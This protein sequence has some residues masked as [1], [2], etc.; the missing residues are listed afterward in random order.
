MRSLLLQVAAV[1]DDQHQEH[2]AAVLAVAVDRG[3]DRAGGRGAARLPGDGERIPAHAVGH[4]LRG[5]RVVL[6]GGSRSEINSVVLRDQVRLIEEGPGIARG[7]RRQ[8]AGLGRTLS[9]GRRHQALQ[10]DQ[11]Q[12][13]AA[14][15]RP[16]G[17]RDPQG[18]QADRGPHVQP[19]QQRARRRQS[20]IAA[21]FQGFEL[22]ST[23][24]VRARRAGPWS[25]CSMPTAACSNSEIWADLAV[26]Q[27]LFKRLNSFQTLRLRLESPAA[28]AALQELRRERSAAQARRQIRGRVLRRPVLAHLRSDPETRLAAG[29]RYGA[30]RARRRAQHHVQLGRGPRVGDRDLARDRLRRLLRLCRHALSNRSSSPRSAD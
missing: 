2:P 8:A 1:T 23:V 29:D 20:D 4:R 28:L 22:G 26:V 13:A 9:H 10:R 21:Q 17:R 18:H 30:R 27:S 14:R 12:P 5:H 3:L 24:V 15:H 6:R 7:P 19:R 25:A 16:G 11:G